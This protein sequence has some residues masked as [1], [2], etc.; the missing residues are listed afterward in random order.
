MPIA[1]AK[2]DLPDNIVLSRKNG[3][4]ELSHPDIGS[5]FV[6]FVGGK[7]RHRRLFGGGRGQPLARAIGLKSGMSPTVIDATPGMGQ[8]AFVLASLGCVV[9]MV[10]RSP[11]VAALLVD[12]LARASSDIEVGGLVAEHLSVRLADTKDYLAGL[13]TADRPQVVYLDP[14][15]PER[16]KSALVKKEMR[17]LQALVGEDTD[18]ADLLGTALTCASHR[19]V[20]KRPAGATPIGN[21][22]A[23]A[24]IASKNTRYDVYVLKAF[25]AK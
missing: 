16:R 11:A 17:L 22:K 7:S 25:D 8:D 19:V 21:H 3:V 15:Y 14:M 13:A 12:A 18:S 10:E 20:V 2:I 1:E 5:V 6:D 23:N 9:T 24:S 4:L